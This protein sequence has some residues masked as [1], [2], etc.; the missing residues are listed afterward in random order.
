MG[1]SARESKPPTLRK[2]RESAALSL[3]EGNQQRD[4]AVNQ[5]ERHLKGRPLMQT[6]PNRANASPP[7]S[8]AAFS[9]SRPAADRA[10]RGLTI[11]AML[12]ILVSIL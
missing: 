1:L 11:A 2:L 4:R 7:T 9:Q 3:K 6:S 10:Y 5:C 8:S 12:L